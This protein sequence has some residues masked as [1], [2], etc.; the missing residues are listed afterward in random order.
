MLPNFLIFFVDDWGYGDIGA[1]WKATV[2]TPHLD[3]LAKNSL[4]FTDFH[5]MSLCTPSRA[6][7]LTGRL[8]AR[9]GVVR[10]F[11]PWSVSGLPMNE[12]TIAELLKPRGYTTG[13]T[14]KVGEPSLL[15]LILSFSYSVLSLS[16]PLSRSFLLPPS[17]SLSRTRTYCRTCSG[18]WE[19]QDNTRPCIADSIGGTASRCRTITAAQ[20][21][22]CQTSRLAR[23]GSTTPINPELRAIHALPKTKTSQSRRVATRLAT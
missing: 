19:W 21:T 23:G 4:R 17:L 11:N 16:L 10:N 13:M 6:A 18:I 14:G 20:T 22:S 3:S 7:L 12:S 9:T 1:N 8:G 15:S 2:E 5:A